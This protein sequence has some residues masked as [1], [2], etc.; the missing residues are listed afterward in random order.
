MEE[1]ESIERLK[2]GDVGGLEYL[3]RHYQVRAMRAA[4][5]ITHDVPLA[6]D[7]VQAAFVKAY[8]RIGQF[9]AGRAFGPWFLRSVIHDAIKAATKRDRVDP[10][11]GGLANEQ[12][13]DRIELTDRQLSPQLLWE[14]AETA[15]EVWAALRQLSPEQRAAIVS[16]YFFDLSEAEMAGT[17]KCPTST[18]KW[19]LHAAR[20]RLRILL[21]PTTPE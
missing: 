15:R 16:R 3:V 7:V 19:R 9:D 17:L 10:L 4:Y 20:E 21:R 8:E 2:R 1:K 14:R 5:L 11:E 18:V 12:S 6:Q 13:S